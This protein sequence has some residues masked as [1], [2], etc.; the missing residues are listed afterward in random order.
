MDSGSGPERDEF[1]LPPVHVEIPDDARELDAD[2]EAY[3]RELRALR[4]RRRSD[5]LRRP[6]RRRGLRLGREGMALPLLAC[7]LMLA[8]ITST[9]LVMFAADQT[10]VPQV[11]GSA[12]KPPA[13]AGLPAGKAGHQLPS[14][15]IIVG[16]GSVP[17]RSLAAGR[18]LVLALIPQ[19]CGC[20]PALR[21]L[22]G[23]AGAAQVRLYLVGT[24]AQR[25]QLSQLAAEAGQP[26]AQV[27]DDTAGV[28][29]SVYGQ[30]G[31][32]AVLVRTGGTV[33]Y[34]A[35]DLSPAQVLGPLRAQLVQLG[36]EA[37]SR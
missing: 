32:T 13:G 22:A 1:G 4:R 35:R 26:P 7:C 23:L 29:A 19:D 10:G 3:R 5:R 2:V 15:G 33:T 34:I 31:L 8:L 14:M 25:N 6:L 16:G 18:P 37:S 36:A 12:A 20:E 17:L 30:Q 21:D 24:S 27:A 28:L 9:L 11:S